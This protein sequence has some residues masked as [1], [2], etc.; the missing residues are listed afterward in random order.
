MR[1]QKRNRRIGRLA[2]SLAAMSAVTLASSAQATID[3]AP[4][5]RVIIYR[6]II[7]APPPPPPVDFEVGIGMVVPAEVELFALPETVDVGPVP[8][9]RYT[10]VR[11]QVILV[12]P[13]TR[14]VLEIIDE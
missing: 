5:D 4:R 13:V 12:D 7:E 3:L 2:A 11:R 1:P 10:V 6:S 9:Y 8:D 14:E